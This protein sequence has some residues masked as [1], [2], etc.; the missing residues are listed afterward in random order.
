[1]HPRQIA[2]PACAFLLLATSSS[3]AAIVKVA[4]NGP[5]ST[6][7]AGVDAASAGDT[8]LV[9]AGVYAGTVV[10]PLGKDGLTIKATGKVVL[11]A[12]GPLGAAAGAGIELEANDVTLRGL[13]VRNAASIIGNPG[14]G[15]RFLGARGRATKCAVLACEDAGFVA[16]GLDAKVDL[17]RCA[18][19]EVGIVAASA[20]S[21]FTITKVVFEAQTTHAIELL[22]D[23]AVDV[24][25]C[26]V[27]GGLNGVRG[28][29][30][31]SNPNTRVVDCKFEHLQGAAVVVNAAN[32][33][34]EGCS[35]KRSGSAFNLRGDGL[36]VRD[37]LVDGAASNSN[38][39]L[40]RNSNG[41][42]IE[43]NRFRSAGGTVIEI[44]DTAQNAILVG[45]EAKRSTPSNDIAV[46]VI[47][48]AGCQ[49]RDCSAIDAGGDGFDINAA[50]VAVEDCLAL[51]C[52]RDGFDVDST[53]T[54]ASLV[55]CVARFCGAE[56]LDNSGPTTTATGGL[57]KNNRIDVTN[58]GSLTLT[59]VTFTTGG[60]NVTPV[61]D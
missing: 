15:I 14:D 12:R 11:D 28:S 3:H 25:K 52:G 33:L 20:T 35:V 2:L 34:I 61:L 42:L 10:V 39:L 19:N 49:L 31:N 41:A 17:S 44:Q 38:A 40:V 51:R 60:T 54:A 23:A 8:V 27:R 9:A 53:A 43:D 24:S 57:F 7:Q 18:S 47:D 36:V 50:D 22:T 32:L 37:N 30:S 56:G 45:N 55:D 48:G 4:K 59:A 29:F 1:M 26:I 58:D 5:L 16:F 21:T 13:E 6:I 46:F